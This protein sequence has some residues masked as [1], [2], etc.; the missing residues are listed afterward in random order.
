MLESDH[1][2]VDDTLSG[3]VGVSVV[4]TGDQCLQ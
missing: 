3:G 2:Q 4:S 1:C